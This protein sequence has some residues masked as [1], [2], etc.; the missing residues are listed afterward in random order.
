MVDSA[1]SY[2][3]QSDLFAD[4][5]SNTDGWTLG[6]SGTVSTTSWGTLLGLFGSGGTVNRTINLG[7]AART[8]SL[9]FYRVDSWDSEYFDITIAGTRVFRGQFR[10][11]AVE[12]D[13][14]LSAASQAVGSYVT[15]ITS[16]GF[17]GTNVQN[18]W[19]DQKYIIT[20]AAP[21]S[22]GGQNITLSSTLDSAYT[23][24]SWAIKNFTVSDAAIVTGKH[25]SLS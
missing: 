14:M 12:A 19:N 11:T 16:G 10:V 4:L 22:S 15:G 2:L 18:T 13:N 7:G 6:T 20:I 5:T 9:E 8:I 3:R 24:E 25:T 17:A 1:S 23:D 21:S